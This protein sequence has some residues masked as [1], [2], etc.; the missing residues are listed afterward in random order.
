M[1]MKFIVIPSALNDETIKE[2]I[3]LRK[4]IEGEQQ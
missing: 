4:K 2:S 1:S 3:K